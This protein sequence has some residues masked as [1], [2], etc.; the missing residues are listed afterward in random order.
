[1][2]ISQGM[3]RICLII[4][5]SV[6]TGSMVFAQKSNKKDKSL[7]YYIRYYYDEMSVTDKRLPSFSEMVYHKAEKEK[8]YDAMRISL[9]MKFSYYYNVDKPDSIKKYIG[10]IKSFT[11]RHKMT[12]EYYNMWMQYIFYLINKSRYSEALYQERMMLG[13]AKKEK[14]LQGM[15][16]CYFSIGESYFRDS[17]YSAGLENL[18]KAAQIIETHKIKCKTQSLLYTE[19]ANGYINLNK[20]DEAGEYF[21]KALACAADNYDV[22]TALATKVNYYCHLKNPK[23]YQKGILSIIKKIEAQDKDYNDVH[24]LSAQLYYYKM[25]GDNNKYIDIV[26]KLHDIG[27]FSDTEYFKERADYFEK[28]GD[29]G[30]AYGNLKRSSEINDSLKTSRASVNMSDYKSLLDQSMLNQQ[31]QELQIELKGKQL[32]N[33]VFI[34][35]TLAM[36]LIFMAYSLYKTKKLNKQLEQKNQELKTMREEAENGKVLAEKANKVKDAFI[37]NMSHEIR[38]PLNAI[39][40]FSQVLTEQAGEREDLKEMS[41]RINSNSDNL[42][43]LIT[44]VF[45]ISN[46]D[47]DDDCLLK[48]RP[49]SINRLIINAVNKYRKR[50]SPEVEISMELMEEQEFECNEYLIRIVLENLISNAVKF[51]KE[52]SIKITSQCYDKTIHITICDTGCG[53]PEDKREWVFGR[54]NKGSNFSQG[55]GL[56]LAICREAAQKLNGEVYVDNDYNEGTKMVFTFIVN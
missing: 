29:I 35:I 24:F 55:S 19:I 26:E 8:N 11:R 16:L 45:D 7:E 37:E 6:L 40:G 10:L 14:S 52:G 44:D 15:A 47:C 13:E 41:E 38:T 51:T 12:D 9:C 42:L 2:N 25:I 33:T 43:K 30:K 49:T 18:N 3:K 46:L 50:L 32:Q 4:V 23:K 22:S 20:M 54:F 5:L 17:N 36:L 39:V 53:I 1:M 31:N 27:Y 56:G 28:K 34:V 21:N 48:E